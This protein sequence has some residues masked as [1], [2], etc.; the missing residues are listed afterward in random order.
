M[1]FRR[2]SS[3]GRA[4]LQIVESRCEGDQVRQQVIATLGRFDELQASGQL[5]RLVRS[6]A[7]FAAKA[8]VL[9][10]ASDEAAMKIAVRRIG[11]ALLFERL[12]GVLG[13]VAG[14]HRRRDDADPGD[15]PAVMEWNPGITIE[16]I[17]EDT[18]APYEDRNSVNSTGRN[19][20]YR[21]SS[22]Q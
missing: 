8:M 12:A 17:W 5:E 11:P 14:R 7:R 1:Y 22:V 4:Y 19:P 18:F 2:K 16:M 3:A 20:H 15:R 10:A 9:S 21:R 6:G 13:D